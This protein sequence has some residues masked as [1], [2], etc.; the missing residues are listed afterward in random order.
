MFIKNFVEKWNKLKI[1]SL[2]CRKVKQKLNFFSHFFRNVKVDNYE[3][4]ARWKSISKYFIE[5][6]KKSNL[7]CIK[8]LGEYFFFSK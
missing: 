4:V 1:Y 5:E 2:F 6:W 7:T 3:F 8:L